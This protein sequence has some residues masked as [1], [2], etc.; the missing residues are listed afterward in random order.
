MKSKNDIPL[1]DKKEVCLN[2]HVKGKCMKSCSRKGSHCNLPRK[3]FL[4]L[5]DNVSCCMKKQSKK[6]KND[7]NIDQ[8]KKKKSK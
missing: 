2:Y 1:L 4:C 5:N 8:E 7:W 6:R 3:L